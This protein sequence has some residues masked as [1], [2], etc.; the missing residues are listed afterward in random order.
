MKLTRYISLGDC[1]SV[2]KLGVGAADLFATYLARTRSLVPNLFAEDLAYM[3]SVVRRQLRRVQ[4]TPERVLVTLTIGQDD[5]LRAW[6]ENPT[7]RQMAQEVGNL[8]GLYRT[9]VH[10]ILKQL[11]NAT[12]MGCTV[13]DPSDGTGD[14]PGLFGGTRRPFPHQHVALFN[15][16][17]RDILARPRTGEST[18]C[19]DL[20]AR[21]R[22]KG[23]KATSHE[24]YYNPKLYLEPG[25]RGA[26]AITGEWS[27]I[28]DELYPAAEA[29]V[30]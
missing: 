13:P 8:V 7:D 14:V 23:N 27:R 18:V 28:V 10:F 4:Q 1:Y 11:P 26:F 15:D 6:A 21:F 17:V 30:S 12:L 16:G 5:L 29:K 22:G 2:G 9:T 19:A 24:L 3:T 20:H 25:E